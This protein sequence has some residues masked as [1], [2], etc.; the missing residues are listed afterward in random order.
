MFHSLPMS[1]TRVRVESSKNANSIGNVRMSG[2]SKIHQSTDCT[3]IWSVMHEGNILRCGS[4]HRCVKTK[5]RLHRRQNSIA[6][7]EF[8]PFQHVENILALTEGDG[9]IGSI[10]NNFNV[11]KERSLS[12]IS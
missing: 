7:C 5:A 10:S 2:N 9:A 11:E 12:Q 1:R 3:E 8:K 6:I 4:T